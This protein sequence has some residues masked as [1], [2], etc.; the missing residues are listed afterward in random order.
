MMTNYSDKSEIQDLEKTQIHY[1]AC[2]G[3]KLKSSLR[4]KFDNARTVKELK[5]AIEN[6]LIQEWTL[7]RRR[8]TL[9][10]YEQKGESY[11]AYVQD[12]RDLAKFT[13]IQD[14]IRFKCGHLR[15]KGK[16]QLGCYNCGQAVQMHLEEFIA[17]LI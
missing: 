9:L 15:C 13:K 1:E 4:V 12:V 14:T 3:D 11:E 8:A 16:P 2:M 7:I 10:S 17:Q 5:K 6:I